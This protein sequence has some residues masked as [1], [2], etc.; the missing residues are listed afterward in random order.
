MVSWIWIRIRIL[1]ADPDPGGITRIN[2]NVI[3][4]KWIIVTGTLF[5]L[6][7]TF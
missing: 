7:V 4:I 3:G 1:N 2:R 6:K 5:S